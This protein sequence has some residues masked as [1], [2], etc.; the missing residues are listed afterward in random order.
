[1]EMCIFFVKLLWSCGLVSSGV[2]KK[3]CTFGMCVWFEESE[4]KYLCHWIFLE[5]WAFFLYIE[6]DWIFFICW[7]LGMLWFLVSIF[8]IGSMGATE[9]GDN[10]LLSD[11]VE[12][13]QWTDNYYYCH[14]YHHHHFELSGGIVVIRFLR[15]L[16]CGYK[17]IVLG[18]AILCFFFSQWLHKIICYSVI[19]FME[20]LWFLCENKNK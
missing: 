6:S 5:G 12:L 15:I 3:V 20:T 13:R 10:T 1:M 19:M 14:Y 9:V 2:C 8:I 7:F 16:I 11:I 17:R 4:V 18:Q